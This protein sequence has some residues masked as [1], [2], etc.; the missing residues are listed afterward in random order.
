MYC[1][2]GP[3]NSNLIKTENAVP[4]NPENRANIK[5][6][7]PI[8]FALV[9][10]NHLSVPMLIEDFLLIGYISLNLLSEIIIFSMDENFSIFLSVT[11]IAIYLFIS[12]VVNFSVFYII[13]K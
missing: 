6:K 10:K 11:S 3:L 1:T 5:Y 8:S 2:P 13:F 7:V 12:N 4:S 9:D